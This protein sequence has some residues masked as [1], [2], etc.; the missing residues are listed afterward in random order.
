MRSIPNY[1]GTLLFPLLSHATWNF[2]FP[3]A[4]TGEVEWTGLVNHVQWTIF[5][6]VDLLQEVI[7][8]DRPSGVVLAP[9]QRFVLHCPAGTMSMECANGGGGLIYRAKSHFNLSIQVI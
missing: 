4:N 6:R 5:G 1:T 2:I 3:V 9:P 7:E 8:G